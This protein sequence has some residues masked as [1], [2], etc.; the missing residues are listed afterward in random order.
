MAGDEPVGDIHVRSTRLRGVRIGGELA[1]RVA[2]DVMA[3]T[4]LAPCLAGR[5]SLRDLASL[6]E[7]RPDPLRAAARLLRECGF[8]CT[9]YEDGFDVDPAA[10]GTTRLPELPSDA[11]PELAL[12]YAVLGV[13]LGVEVSVD[14]PALLDALYPGFADTLAALGVSFAREESP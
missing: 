2:D 13:A 12:A 14:R 11:A 6:R 4:A 1:F 3:L 7:R 10:G 8:E 9:D 5:L